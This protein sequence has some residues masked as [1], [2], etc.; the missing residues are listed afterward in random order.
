M[1]ST[2]NAASGHS[3][4]RRRS[5]GI[6]VL[7]LVGIIGLP[8]V[9][10]VATDHLQRQAAEGRARTSNSLAAAAVASE[11]EESYQQRVQIL[12]DLPDRPSLASGLAAGNRSLLE[13]ALNTA[14]LDG[15]YCRLVL[16]SPGIAPA[17]AAAPGTCWSPPA[18]ASGQRGVTS[19]GFGI[20]GSSAFMSVALSGEIP[21]HAQASIQA[22][23]A[24]RS[25]TQTIIAGAGLHSTLV[26]GKTILSSN[27]P[28]LVGKTVTVPASLALIRSNRPGNTN[29]YAPLIHARVLSAYQPVPGTGIGV[30]FSVT[31]S[32]AYASA[33]H[34]SHLLFLG[35]LGLLFV[36]LTL[37]ALVAE[38]IRR[39]DRARDAAYQESR[40]AGA[41]AALAEARQR[42]I[43]ETIAE[44][45]VVYDFDND[46]RHVPV[47]RNPALG[48]LGGFSFEQSREMAVTRT[49]PELVDSDEHPIH[50][51][52]LP[53][54]VVA[55]TGTSASRVFGIRHLETHQRRWLRTTANPVLDEQG[56]MV[57]MVSCVVDVTDERSARSGPSGTD[58][59]L[60][61]WPPKRVNPRRRD[62]NPN[63]R[64]ADLRSACA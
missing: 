28:G 55:R 20:E 14:R 1:A 57:G 25:L 6:G 46:G 16:R 31:T 32:V 17:I 11:V 9:G 21:G 4:S 62:G 15:Q 51:D 3:R 48:G 30:F 12:R 58:P 42:T 60:K 19:E 34:L 36:A 22:V 52:D 39:R 26:S 50:L 47:L 40:A 33:N 64:S 7:V 18:P 41:A 43:F 5:W 35:Y 56:V 59:V 8:T 38:M 23:F 54:A 13:Q 29:V 44:G 63:L 10:L 37:A 24:V 61:R 49:G 45:I 27:A 53:V 2:E